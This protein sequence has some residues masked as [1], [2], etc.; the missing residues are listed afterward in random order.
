VDHIIPISLNGT[1]DLENL[2]I[3]CRSCNASKYN[4]VTAIDPLT[5]KIVPLFHP[6]KDDWA[7]HFTWS[8]NL[9]KMNGKT[10]IG[11]ATISR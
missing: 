9:L 4:V 2:A 10:A 11:R 1:N 3:A 6:R 8:E 5:N 7:A